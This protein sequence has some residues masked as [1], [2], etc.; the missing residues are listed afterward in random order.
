MNTILIADDH[1]HLRMVVRTTLDLPEYRIV[2]ATDGAETLQLAREEKPDLLILDWMMPELSG[3]QVL[4][5]IR[6]DPD[7]GTL[8]VIM[9][10]AKALKTDR[11]EAL[12]KGIRGYLVKPFSPLELMDRVEKALL[13][14]GSID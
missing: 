13:P 1:E 6:A 14:L 2:E 9:L 11:N 7:I 5:A 12:M 3:M 10:T 4:D 8:P